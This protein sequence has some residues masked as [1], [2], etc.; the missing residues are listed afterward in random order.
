MCQES[1]G[2][3]NR[4]TKLS[5]V[6]QEEIGPSLHNAVRAG[7]LKKLVAGPPYLPRL[8]PLPTASLAPRSS[9]WPGLP[10]SLS[11]GCT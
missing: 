1:N 11:A 10:C 6:H 5:V 4:L 9:G 3:D 8:G 2:A 7:Q